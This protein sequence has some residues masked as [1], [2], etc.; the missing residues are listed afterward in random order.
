MT[1][2]RSE[3]QG[4]PS[5]APAGSIPR[6]RSRSSTVT[7]FRTASARRGSPAGSS[8]RAASTSAC[9]CATRTTATSAARFTR[10][11]L[12]AAPV[13]VSRRAE[14]A[15]LRAVVVNSGN[16]NVSSGA[17][18]IAVAE[19]MAAAGAEAAG[20]PA[21]RVGVAST[22][23]IGVGLERNRVVAGIEQAAAALSPERATTSPTRFSRPTGGRSTRASRSHLRVAPCRLCAQAKGGGMISPSFATMLCFVET[24]AA[25]DVAHPRPPA[26]RRGRA[27]L[28]AHLGRRPALDERLRVHDR[29]RALRHRGEAGRRR[30]A[31]VGHALDALLKQLAI[32]IVADGEGATRVARL[33]VRG[34][35]GAAE[36]VARAVANSP[37]VK[38]A[39]FGGDP[40][41]GRMLQ[42]AGQALPDLG[43]AR[44]R[45]LDRGGPGRG[46]QRCGATGRS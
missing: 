16:A 19:A 28:R 41:W 26:R 1:V 20:V 22:G 29:G 10:N 18:G 36:P 7:S 46:R 4:R 8:A 44:V 38:C 5:S 23:V 13:T 2:S 12:V 33:E 11:A 25:V 3:T 35:T 6:T 32:E 21:R 9:S 15:R 30:R 45:P 37:L 42:A 24:D 40:N 27:F 39:L 34:A 31:G 17:E 43:E 14:L